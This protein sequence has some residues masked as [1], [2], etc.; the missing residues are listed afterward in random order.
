MDY[1]DV[2]PVISGPLG[3]GIAGMPT[4]GFETR[5]FSLHPQIFSKTGVTVFRTPNAEFS[6]ISMHDVPSSIDPIP[7][8]LWG[9]S[10][11]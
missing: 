8:C 9:E 1:N 2:A 7:I 11:F 3:E 5:H 6:L 4:K 10:F